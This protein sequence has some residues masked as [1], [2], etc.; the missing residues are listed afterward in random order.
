MQILAE[1]HLLQGQEHSSQV[2]NAMRAQEGGSIM[3]HLHRFLGKSP[4]GQ[5]YQWHPMAKLRPVSSFGSGILPQKP[6]GPETM[7][8]KSRGAR[9]LRIVKDLCTTTAMSPWHSFLQV[10]LEM[11]RKYPFLQTSHLDVNSS[12][13]T[14]DA[15]TAKRQSSSQSTN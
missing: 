4:G 9:G 14:R 6:C 15:N 5:Q 3:V 8:L 1:S 10:E 7:G 12:T 13:K 11:S 2:P